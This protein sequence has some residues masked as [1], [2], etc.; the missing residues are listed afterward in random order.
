MTRLPLVAALVLVPAVSFAGPKNLGKGAHVRPA[1]NPYVVGDPDDPRVLHPAPGFLAHGFDD[2]YVEKMARPH[3]PHEVF[4]ELEKVR[5]NPAV[6]LSAPVPMAANPYAATVNGRVLVVEGNA[7]ICPTTSAGLT[8]D[9]NNGLFS[10]AQ[11]V[12]QQLGDNFDFITIFTTFTDADQ[13]VAAFY[14]PLKND[15]QGLGACNFNAGQ[16]FGCEF[17]QLQGTGINRLQG[18][19]FMNSLASWQQWDSF[20]DGAVHPFD[21]FDSA[22]YSTL[23]QEIAHRWG[24]GL[25]F[26]DP[27]TGNVSTKLLGRDQSHWAAWVDTDASVMDG[28]DWG[29]V[30]SGNRYPL[31]NEMDNYST[32]DLYAMGALPV[33][34][35]RPFFFIDGAKYDEKDSGTFAF[36]LTGRPVGAADVLASGIP[37][38]ALMKANGINLGAT[39]EE[40]DLS[41]QDI[42][43]AEG[44]RCPDPDHTQRSFQQAIALVTRPGQT[45]AQASDD[46]ANLEVV[47]D[48][49]EKWW[50]D[51]T[52]HALTLCTDPNVDCKQAIGSLGGGT[53]KTQGDADFLER[54]TDATVVML[55]S[56]AAKVREPAGDAPGA[57]VKNAH[58]AV[59]LDGGGAKHA[60]LDTTDV[61]VGDIA[62]GQDV[63]APVKISVDGDY[64]CGSSL[65]VVADLQAD[66]APTV[67]EEYRLFPGYSNIFVENFAGD[68]DFKVNA[69]GKDGAT[70]GALV[71]SDVALSCDM[72]PRTPEKD[73]TPG[74]AGAYVTGVD[75]ELDGDTSLWSPEIDLTGTAAPELAYDFW[76]EGAPNDSLLVELS[77]DGKKFV[78]AAEETESL[79]GWGL[80]RIKIRDVFDGRVPD[81]V[82]ARWI[83]NGHGHLEGGVDNVRVIDPSGQCRGIVLGFC[84]C[85][86]TGS[87]APQTALAF[88]L[89]LLGL[90]AIKRG[91]SSRSPLRRRPR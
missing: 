14:L 3:L 68:D 39:G 45:A 77:E 24:S 52:G 42:V 58:I 57:T 10:V 2:G 91:R 1:P 66:N 56:G 85:T 18:I 28:W 71:R 20:Y 44:N 34:S 29:P 33:A 43:D 55:A 11:T 4:E 26:V 13:N 15:V 12:L 65:I 79:H 81:H 78:S 47:A 50:S 30:Q 70:Q 86:N 60:K 76:F 27:R 51:R 83:F 21:D 63:E 46:V 19:V 35:A 32:L 5:G 9:T 74:T 87:A 38:V 59:K 49:W 23:G 54:G 48:T 75:S 90:R 89:G 31:L 6:T 25:R 73:N 82:T 88:V 22:V 8:F 7:Q 72:T 16:T 67:R 84:G 36:G 53:V 41:I 40:V 69:D 17:D 80:N 62:P 37:S 61:D 64:E